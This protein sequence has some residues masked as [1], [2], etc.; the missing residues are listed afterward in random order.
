MTFTIAVLNITVV[1]ENSF[2]TCCVCSGRTI[3]TDA[4]KCILCSSNVHMESCSILDFRG[5][6]LSLPDINLRICRQCICKNCKMPIDQQPHMC[7]CGSCGDKISNAQRRVHCRNCVQPNH[8]N[9]VS[10]DN[11]GCYLCS[12][13]QAL[14]ST[15]LFF[16]Y[17]CLNVFMKFHFVFVLVFT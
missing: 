6:R 10:V 15:F 8:L 13:C 9:C 4:V 3:A 12:H 7:S 11:D 5:N 14:Q 16:F 2:T 17:F 1:A